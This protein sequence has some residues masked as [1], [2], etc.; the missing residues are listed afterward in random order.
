MGVFSDLYTTL[1]SKY[2]EL[3]KH[4]VGRAVTYLQ[5]YGYL[6]KKDIE[7][8]TLA[9]I[10]KAVKT[11][12]EFFTECGGVLKGDG[13]IGPKT[14]SAMELPRCH[15]TDAKKEEV[16][17]NKNELT[18]V[19]V[20][21]VEDGISHTEQ[22]EVLREAWAEWEKVANIKI[23]EVDNKDD[24]DIVVSVGRGRR[25]GFDRE[26]GTLAWAEL[27]TGFSDQQLL[28]RFDLDEL[29]V[30]EGGH[31]VKLKNVGAH[32]FGHIFGLI[33]GLGL[34]S[35]FYNPDIDKPQQNNDIPRIQKLYGPPL[36]VPTPDP[37][38][39]PEPEPLPTPVPPKPK[40]PPQPE[41]RTLIIKFTGNI[42]DINME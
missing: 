16:K 32:E 3:N 12:Q 28:V 8:L 35:P 5:H 25:Y 42:Q 37:V 24:A 29:W 11:F 38:P 33:H 23:T 18:Y 10:I 7:E 17:W 27:P 2:L 30:I 19:V 1:K 9:D 36:D 31:G 14:L 40:D 21:W 20:G 15:F 13:E 41:A 26:G 34:M 39:V 6:P 4:R 22:R